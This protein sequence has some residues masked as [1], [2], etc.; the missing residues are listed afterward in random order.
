MTKMTFVASL[1]L[2]WFTSCKNDAPSDNKPA[3]TATPELTAKYLEGNWIANG[4]VAKIAAMGSVVKQLGN[5]GAPYA[6][7]FTFTPVKKDSVIC[8]NHMKMW[9]L[10]Y[11]ITSDSTVEATLE[12]GKKIYMQF[13]L[14]A[15]NMSLFDGTSGKMRIDYF[16]QTREKMVNGYQAFATALNHNLLSGAFL[17]PGANKTATTVGFLPT[18]A[19][20]GLGNYDIFQVCPGGDCLVAGDQI[21]ALFL[22]NSKN[23]KE[24][25]WFGFRYS[26]QLD[27]LTIYSLKNERPNEKAGFTV[28][29]PAFML[30]KYT[31]EPRKK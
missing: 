15:K 11:Q 14:K 4:F 8:Y 19:V 13:D 20:R 31:P 10:P 17:L 6:F 26:V 1:L 16:T 7:A 12:D 18:G 3:A 23:P 27:T 28:Q 5:E 29:K 25:G 24:S 21:D 30:L 22:A 2:L 9:T